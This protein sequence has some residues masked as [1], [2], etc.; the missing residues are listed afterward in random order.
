MYFLLP[1]MQIN[2]DGLRLIVGDKDALFM[3]EKVKQGHRYLMLYVDHESASKCTAFDDVVANPVV[4]LPPV[5]D[6]KSVV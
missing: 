6:R 5:I 1:G 2:E 3:I 4:N